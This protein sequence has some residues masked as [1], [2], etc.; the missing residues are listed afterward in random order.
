MI[1]VNGFEIEPTIFPDKTS[2]VWRIDERILTQG[3]YDVRW[4]F[5]S[6]AEIMHL[7]QLKTLLDHYGHGKICSLTIDYLPYARQDKGVD[8][9]ATFALLSFAIVLNSL[10][11]DS[12]WCLDPHSTRAEELIENFNP[13]YPIKEVS[14]IFRETKSDVICYPDSGA[15]MKYSKL[16]GQYFVFGEKTRDPLSGRIIN[17]TLHGDVIGKKVL[18]V[19]DLC[20]GGATFILLAKELARL[21]ICS[22]KHSPYSFPSSHISIIFLSTFSLSGA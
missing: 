16:Y 12:L 7:V 13:Q 3:R 20:D 2:Q 22:S 15:H 11:F 4:K 21:S 10:H 1:D 18:I 9:K 6:E 17:Y 5:E 8:N 14:R 19:D